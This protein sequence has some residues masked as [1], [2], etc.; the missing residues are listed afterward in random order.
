MLNESVLSAI[1]QDSVRRWHSWREWR[2]IKRRSKVQAKL[3]TYDEKYIR[4]AE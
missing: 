4:G 1:W 2:A 3:R